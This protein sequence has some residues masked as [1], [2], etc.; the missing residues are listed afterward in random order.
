M[1]DLLCSAAVLILTAVLLL[2]TVLVTV[3]VAVLI[4]VL[5]TIIILVIH[6]SSSEIS[7][8]VIRNISI[9]CNLCF[10]PGLK[11]KTCQKTGCNGNGY[12][13]SR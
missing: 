10:I 4:I 2:I 3:L 5:G 6:V 12:T 13:A 9:S 1:G 7:F 8:A 11:E